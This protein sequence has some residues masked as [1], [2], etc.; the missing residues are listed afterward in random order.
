MQT[1]KMSEG[2]IVRFKSDYTGYF[3]DLIGKPMYVLQT[4]NDTD[5][6][7][8]TLSGITEIHLVNPIWLEK[9]KLVEVDHAN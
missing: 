9:L 5:G 2:D 1:R 7:R 4:F 3:K 6:Q 8:V